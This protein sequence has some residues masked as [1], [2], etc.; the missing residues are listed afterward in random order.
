MA[1]IMA[2]QA[3]R[4]HRCRYQGNHPP[5]AQMLELLQLVK[6]WLQPEKLTCQLTVEQVVMDW[7][8]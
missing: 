1:V 3:Q 7:Y 4:V 2:V 6:K 8:V 5:G